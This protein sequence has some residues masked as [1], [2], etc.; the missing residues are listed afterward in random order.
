[1]YLIK[2]LLGRA[3]DV[4]HGILTNATYEETLQALEDDFG[5]QHFAA[6]YRCQLTTRTQR[7]GE[8]LQDFATAIE[9]LARRAYPTLSED[10]IWREAGKAFAYGVGDPEIKIQLLLGGE[11]TVNE[12]LRQ[13]LEL[14]AI[15]VAARPHKNSTKTYWGN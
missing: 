11:K 8:S 10:H 14:Q 13:A 12:A 7:A 3:V 1:M 2:A 15:F 5:D 9:Q 4:L 6:V